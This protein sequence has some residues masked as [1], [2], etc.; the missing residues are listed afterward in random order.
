MRRY[1]N[2]NL[3]GRRLFE[4]RLTSRNRMRGDKYYRNLGSNLLESRP[5]LLFGDNLYD[6]DEMDDFYDDD[7]MDN[8]YDDEMDDFYDDDYIFEAPIK[9]TT[10]S[11]RKA[12]RKAY[13]KRKKTPQYKKWKK[14]YDKKRKAKGGKALDRNRSKIAKKAAKYKS[15]AK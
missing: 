11:E 9:K 14:N 4:T 8:F 6:L 1:S 2:R 7:E 13:A 5:Q 15:N 10:A 12:Q 3:R